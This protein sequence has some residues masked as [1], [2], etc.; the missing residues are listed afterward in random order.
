MCFLLVDFSFSLLAL[1]MGVEITTTFSG[2]Q[3]HILFF[4][5]LTDVLSQM[6]GFCFVVVGNHPIISTWQFAFKQISNA[7][8]PAVVSNGLFVVC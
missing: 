7:W 8:F 4:A 3:K 2:S 5:C 1:F 6:L